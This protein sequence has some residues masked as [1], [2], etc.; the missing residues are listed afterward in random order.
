MPGDFAVKETKLPGIFRGQVKDVDDPEMLG[1]AR[2]LIYPMFQDIPTYK[3]PWAVPAFGLFEGAGVNIGAFTVPSVDSWVFVFFENGDMY[4]PVYFAS[5]PTGKNSK[6]GIPVDLV[7]PNYP[8]RKAWRTTSGIEIYIDDTD[9]EIQIKHPAEATVKIDKDGNVEVI[10]VGDVS[11][12]SEKDCTIT[13]TGN[14]IVSGATI[15][16]N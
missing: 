5:A 4:Q 1:R 15:Q 8:T 3:L 2:I 7:E 10:T 9:K 16:L 6:K 14:V 11:V 12:T 13:A